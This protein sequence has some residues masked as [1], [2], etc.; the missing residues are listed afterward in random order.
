MEKNYY[1]NIQ[2]FMVQDLKLSGNEL[3]TYAIVYGFS[4]DGE[5]TFVGSSK[6]I[7]YALGVSRPTAIKALDSLTSKGLIIKSQEKINDVVFNRYK[8]SSDVIKNLNRPY[9]ETLQGGYKE[10]LHSNKYKEI[11]VKNNKEKV[12]KSTKRMSYD[13]QIEEYSDN[14][15][16]RQALKAFIQM[17]NL[18]KK[19]LTNYALKLILNNLDKFAKDDA[20]KIDI[21]NQS[22]E[23]SW[24]GV[25]PIKEEKTNNKAD[26]PTYCTNESKPT[27]MKPVDYTDYL[28]DG[29]FD[30]DG[31]DKACAEYKAWADS[32]R[33]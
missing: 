30:K 7:S 8:V 1:I 12:S 32:T 15:E 6:Y 28:H 31:Y 25:F 26:R 23:H 22:V 29:V 20:T 33:G 3:L 19:P 24:Q 27:D 11:N 18:I 16:L 10:T 17:R 14:E 5:S 2:S 9:K 13:E 4:Q 21:I